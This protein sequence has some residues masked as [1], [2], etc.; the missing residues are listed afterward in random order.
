MK[1]G[2]CKMPGQIPNGVT[3]LISE[4]FSESRLDDSSLAKLGKRILQKA[5]ADFEPHHA[6]KFQV[7]SAIFK[8]REKIP[9]HVT[10]LI[11]EQLTES[12]SDDSSLAKLGKRILRIL[13]CSTA[14]NQNRPL[15]ENELH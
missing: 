12:S 8:K 1:V 5:E 2:K 6:P 4:Q 10:A 13:H 14:I 15:E 3:A 9:N 11:S 7:F